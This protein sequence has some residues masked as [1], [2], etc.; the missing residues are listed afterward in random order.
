M[1]SWCVFCKTG[2]EKNV[3]D[4]VSTLGD[5]IESIVPTRTLQQKRKGKWVE[6]E[7]VLFPGY[8][9]VYAGEGI[10]LN[11]VKQAPGLYKILDYGMGFKELQGSDYE[12]SM[13]IH[14]HEGNI[15]TSKVLTIGRTV[16][17]IE[18][19]LL[20]G[21]GTI[22]KLNKHR[23]RIWVEFEFDGQVRTVSLSA[24]CVEAK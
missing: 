8:V 11:I 21:L 17:V 4:F 16:K 5:G 15:K 22:V 19:P 14:R 10:K 23:R 18:G 6:C 20:D 3:V 1:K 2:F 24:E 13:W 9:F 7:Q 12:Y